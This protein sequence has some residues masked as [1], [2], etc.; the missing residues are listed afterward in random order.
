MY[1]EYMSFLSAANWW[2]IFS[3][4]GP[5]VVAAGPKDGFV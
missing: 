4:F 5:P 1:G 2:F 3:C